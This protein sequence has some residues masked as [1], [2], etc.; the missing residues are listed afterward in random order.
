MNP[1]QTALTKIGL[2]QYITHIEN[3]RQAIYFLENHEDE[4]ELYDYSLNENKI[5]NPIFDNNWNKICD[6]LLKDI[7]IE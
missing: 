6:E 5:F 3:L 1:P 2:I 4:L 7:T